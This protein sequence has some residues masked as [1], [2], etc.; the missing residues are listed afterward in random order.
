[1]PVTK[2]RR[3]GRITQPSE[4]TPLSPSRSDAELTERL[5]RG[6]RWAQQA[7]YRKYVHVVWNLSLRLMG[8][9]ADAA[10]LVRAT[11]SVVLCDQRQALERRMLRCWLF[12]VTVQ[13]ALRT[14]R[15]RRLLRALGYERAERRHRLDQQLEQRLVPELASDLHKL[16]EVLDRLPARRHIAWCLRYMEGCSLDEVASFCGCSLSVAQRELTAARATVQ[17]QLPIGEPRDA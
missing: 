1:M 3:S 13:H 12:G 11:F 5:A 9:R 17:E 2:L 8:N 6:D 7:V 16:G 4:P 14:L 15:R 10:D